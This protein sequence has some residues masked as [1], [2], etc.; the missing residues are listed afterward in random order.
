MK[1]QKRKIRI[2]V[3]INAIYSDYSASIIEGISKFCQENDCTQVVFSVLRGNN[4]SHYD[5]HYDSIK[6]LISPNNLDVLVIASAALANNRSIE[7]LIKDIE[8]LPPM[9]VVSLGLELEGVPSVVVDSKDALEKVIYHIIDEHKRDKFL[10]LRGDSKSKEVIE[11]EQCFKNALASRNIPFDEKDSIQANF[12]L[13]KAY[14]ALDS[15][16]KRN[17]DNKFNAII[18]LN[19]EMALGCIAC[20]E[21]KNIHV[22]EDVSVVGFDN[23]LDSMAYDINLTTVDQ[24][25]EQQAYEAA[26]IAFNLCHGKEPESLITTIYAEPVFRKT[27]GCKEIHNSMTVQNFLQTKELLRNKIHHK[28]SVQLYMLHYFLIESQEPVPLEKL[29]NRLVYCFSLFDILGA[30]LVLYDKPLYNTYDTNFLIP[31]TAVLEMMYTNDTG[32]SLPSVRFNPLEKFLPYDVSEMLSG[33]EIV[34]PV[35]SE[36]YQYGYFVM[37]IGQYEK[38]FY[39]A[40]YELITKE[41]VSSI[42]LSQA[43]KERTK[44]QEMNISLE[45]YSDRLNILSR[46]DDMT[47]LLNR[48]GFYEAS[49]QLIHAYVVNQKKGLV[50]YCDMDGLKSINDTFGHEAGDKAIIAEA[51]ILKDVFRTTD[52]IGR[53]GGDEF[54]IVAPNLSVD[55]LENIRNRLNDSCK[56]FNDESGEAFVLS[57]SLGYAEFSE[58]KNK[59]ETLLNEADKVLYEE[60]RRKKNK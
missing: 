49:Q 7:E 23:V 17:P 18:S 32:V 24:K 31:D 45:E 51:K 52:V 46:T 33:T 14:I 43:E 6:K 39:Q 59:I 13:D 4:V 50:I 2:G 29:Y 55:D 21:D 25:I 22:P 36:S 56:S 10:L 34:F 26:R 58:S 47:K 44:L 28:S 1:T 57:I 37:Q 15:Y 48:R 9:K 12:I 38:I 8:D 53:M 27:C 11:R 16:L 5:F 42:K 3:L 20:L 19:D 35:Y 30:M 41:I 54:A 40:I 60:K